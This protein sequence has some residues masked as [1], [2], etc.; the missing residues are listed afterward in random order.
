VDWRQRLRAEGHGGQGHLLHPQSRYHTRRGGVRRPRRTSIPLALYCL[1]RYGSARPCGAAADEALLQRKDL[2]DQCFF[3]RISMVFSGGLLLGCGP[4]GTCPA[5]ELLGLA[6]LRKHGGNHYPH[7]PW[8]RGQSG[9]MNGPSRLAVRRPAPAA[10]SGRRRGSRTVCCHRRGQRRGHGQRKC[11]FRWSGA[12]ACY[13][14][15]PRR[16]RVLQ[17]PVAAAPT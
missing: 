14:I 8:Q 6:T 5:A 11:Q 4:P 13:T 3:P 12:W 7:S 1:G 17:V 2:Y 9:Q 16:S 10:H 15:G